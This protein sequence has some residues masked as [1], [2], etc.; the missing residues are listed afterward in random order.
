MASLFT[1]ELK[2]GMITT[3]D[4]YSTQGKLILP[5]DTVI[6]KNII[7]KLIN[8]DVVFIEV[9]DDSS[10]EQAKASDVDL[11]ESLQI[12]KSEFNHSIVDTPEY[13][14]LEQELK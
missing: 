5:K 2:E 10:V 14:K 13:K 11:S 9:S 7:N 12:D 4:T 3:T 8:N 6:T 1:S